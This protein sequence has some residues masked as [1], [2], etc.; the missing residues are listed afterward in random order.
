MDPAVGERLFRR[1][2][3]GILAGGGRTVLLAT[4]QHGLAAGADVVVAMEAGGRVAG[5]VVANGPERGRSVSNF[6]S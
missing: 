5:V 3:R 2:L 4:H 1:C 6:P